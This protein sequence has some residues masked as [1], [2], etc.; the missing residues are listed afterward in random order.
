MIGHSQS[1]DRY[2][3]ITLGPVSRKSRELFGPEKPVVFIVRNTK[4]IA[5]LDGL[6]PLRIYKYKGNCGTRN[7]PEKFRDF[8]ET[9]PRARVLQP[10]TISNQG[11][12]KI[13]RPCSFKS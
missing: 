2:F 4:R 6:E 5:K 8:R 10:I 3:L 12:W 13:V 7:R 11:D 1:L 9:G